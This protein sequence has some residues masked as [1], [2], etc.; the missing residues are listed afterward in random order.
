VCV[1]VCVCVC[2][3]GEVRGSF[4]SS[5]AWSDLQ[6]LPALVVGSDGGAGLREAD[7]LWGH[8]Q[9]TGDLSGKRNVWSLKPDKTPNQGAYQSPFLSSLF[10]PISP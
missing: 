6:Y 2:G 3:V 1:C 8:G 4:S 7:G 5:N 9:N 10:C